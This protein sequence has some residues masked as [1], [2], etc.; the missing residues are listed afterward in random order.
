MPNPLFMPPLGSGYSLRVSDG[1]ILIV[2][3]ESAVRAAL[4]LCLRAMGHAVCVSASLD[5]AATALRDSSTSVRLVIFSC[6]RRSGFREIVSIVQQ[7]R[8]PSA[9]VMI[10][11]DDCHSANSFEGVVCAV[12]QLTSPC[13]LME[14]VD[15]ILQPPPPQMRSEPAT[16]CLN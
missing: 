5:D 8:Y 2:N 13:M 6:R 11:C 10:L 12:E 3:E 15:E 16:S 7:S 9:S 4:A 1:L 14:M